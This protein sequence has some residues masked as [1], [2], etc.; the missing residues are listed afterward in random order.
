MDAQSVQV[1]ILSKIITHFL[2]IDLSDVIALK[3]PSASVSVQLIPPS[4]TDGLFRVSVSPATPS[5][6]THTL[7]PLPPSME[8]KG[9]VSKKKNTRKI[10]TKKYSK[11][12]LSYKSGMESE[13]E[14]KRIRRKLEAAVK[15]NNIYSDYDTYVRNHLSIDEMM[16]SKEDRYKCIPSIGIGVYIQ[17][18]K[19]ITNGTTALRKDHYK[20][21]EI[22]MLNR[23]DSLKYTLTSDDIEILTQ[24]Q[25]IYYGNL[26]QKDKTTRDTFIHTL[27]TPLLCYVPLETIIKDF[28]NYVPN[29][30]G[31]L[32]RPVS[33]STKHDILIYQLEETSRE[34]KK[35]GFIEAWHDF[36]IELSSQLTSYLVS[37]FRD[38]YFLNYR[39]NSYRDTFS[40][41]PE[42]QTLFNS[43]KFAINYPLM[44]QYIRE[45]LL[46][47][48]LIPE[49]DN[50]KFDTYSKV[51]TIPIIQEVT[52]DIKKLTESN[53]FDEIPPDVMI[54]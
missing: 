38:I 30:I 39:D 3:D 28:F 24:G 36:I 18:L 13:D 4:S 1:S 2:N 46:A 49:T 33:K 15:S 27:K 54:L 11:V 21:W 9:E 44:D 50:N 37:S 16:Q 17:T 43:I 10:P 26:G 52:S 51:K 29:F 14:E 48:R 25:N 22:R 19:S 20:E 7:P 35:W 40:A 47:H 6:T 12:P 23:P 5:E 53:L 34:I 8:E 42:L 32:N 45:I 41:I 31:C